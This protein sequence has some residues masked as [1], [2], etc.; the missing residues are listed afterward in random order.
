MELHE[1]SAAEAAQRMR[2]GGLD[3]EEYARALLDRRAAVEPKIHALAHFDRESFLAAAANSTETLARSRKSGEPPPPL[4]G[5]PVGVKDNFDTAGVPSRAG[6]ALLADH[7]PAEDAVCLLPLWR[8]GAYLHSKTVTAELAYFDP[9]PTRNPWH[10]THTPGGSSQ[11]SAAGV[12]AGLFPLALGSQT[13]GS[14]IRPAAYCGV[15]GFTLSRGSVPLTGVLPFAPSVDQLGIFARTVEDAALA[16]SV[17]APAG[18]SL[19][20]PPAPLDRPPFLGLAREYFVS[21]AED[22]MGRMTIHV[23]RSLAATGPIVHVVH[24]PDSFHDI[25]PHHRLIMEVEMARSQRQSFAARPEVYGREV[26]ELIERGLAA[27]DDEYRKALAHRDRFR[28][29]AAKLLVEIDALLLPATPSSAPYGLESTGDPR[30]NIPWT[31]AGLPVITLPAAL[32]AGG[33]PLGIQLVGAPNS[34]AR[35][36]RTARF[37]EERL[38]WKHRIAPVRG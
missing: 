16:Y 31:S 11:G 18:G 20:I 3:P 4:L 9:G 24:L 14:V 34:E 33:L 12:A 6:S 21:S 15:V 37:L 35:L 7:V 13:A 27:R 25:H 1:L 36:L 38:G 8:S 10:L 23:A 29:D 26:R 32:G 22:E 2:S 5:V 28:N 19:E 17:L 30:F